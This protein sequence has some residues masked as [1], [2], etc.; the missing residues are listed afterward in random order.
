MA[1]ESGPTGVVWDPPANGS[2]YPG[3]ITYEPSK[4][5]PNGAA[6]RAFLVAPIG[7]VVEGLGT[8]GDAVYAETFGSYVSQAGWTFSQEGGL[9]TLRDDTLTLIGRAGAEADTP[10]EVATWSDALGAEGVGVFMSGMGWTIT[11]DTAA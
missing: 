6:A 3:D 1:R 5:F 8:A 2:P 10:P 11:G 4:R 9:W 7:V